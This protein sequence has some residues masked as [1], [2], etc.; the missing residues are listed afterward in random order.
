MRRAGAHSTSHLKTQQ[1]GRDNHVTD[2][3][4]CMLTQCACLRKQESVYLTAGH[5]RGDQQ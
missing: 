4:E 5:K 3:N 2:K 1:R